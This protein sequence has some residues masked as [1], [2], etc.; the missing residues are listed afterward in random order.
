MTEPPPSHAVPSEFL[1][2]SNSYSRWHG[3][4]GKRLSS[5]RLSSTTLD[6]LYLSSLAKRR[7]FRIIVG[8]AVR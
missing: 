3:G 1:I 6:E 4:L 8:C 2:D 5:F 7:E